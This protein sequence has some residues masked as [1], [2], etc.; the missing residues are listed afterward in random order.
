MGSIRKI[1]GQRKLYA[2][3]YL[4][5]KGKNLIDH[6]ETKHEELFGDNTVVSRICQCL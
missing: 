5:N 2:V 1:F 4:I 6:C 3:K